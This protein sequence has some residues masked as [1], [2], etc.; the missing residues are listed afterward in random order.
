MA[1]WAERF[2]TQFRGE[3]TKTDS[4]GQNN[5]TEE[6]LHSH[7][8]LY[9]LKYL[10]FTPK[11]HQ[12][13]HDLQNSFSSPPT[14]AVLATVGASSF[15]LGFRL[16]SVRHTVWRRYT[17]VAD[18]PPSVVLRGRILSAA[19][20]DT[21]RFLHEPTLIHSLCKYPKKSALPIR[22][23]T[24][25]A[26]EVAKFGKP[27]QPHGEEAAEYLRSFAVGRTAWA[28]ILRKDQYGR[29]V[30]EVWT[31][32]LLFSRKYLDEEMLLKGYAEVYAGGG[33]V[34][35]RLGIDSYKQMM[36]SARSGRLGIWKDGHNRESA[37]EFKARVK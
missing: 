14:L 1:G 22:I 20:G 15:L 24:I 26:P 37:A 31:R 8:S 35:G 23:C 28:R 21:V 25:D 17:S 7:L 18:L 12:L 2:A 16:G 11:S 33:A 34:Y 29:A 6:S 27:G 10:N 32:R 30:A 36:D 4:E 13:L 3:K 19:D 5:G 9:I